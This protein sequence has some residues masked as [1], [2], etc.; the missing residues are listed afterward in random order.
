M[1]V[2]TREVRSAVSFCVCCMALPPGKDRSG[3]FSLAS[4]N[5]R[6][7]VA[8]WQAALLLLLFVRIG[9]PSGPRLDRGRKVSACYGCRMRCLI[10]K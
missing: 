2:K 1:G 7:A 4:A 3:L 5:A 6:L 9:L 10:K 8:Q